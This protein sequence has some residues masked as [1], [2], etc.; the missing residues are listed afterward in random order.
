[1]VE[2]AARNE[3]CTRTVRMCVGSMFCRGGLESGGG[4]SC[5]GRKCCSQIG[6]SFAFAAPLCVPCPQAFHPLEAFRA[7][8]L[9]I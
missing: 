1:V 8:G 3:V 5:H 2:L 6:W 4:S 9:C 7:R